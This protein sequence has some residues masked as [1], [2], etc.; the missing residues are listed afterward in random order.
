MEGVPTS[1]ARSGRCVWTVG[2]AVASVSSRTRR[3]GPG[4]SVVRRR[5]RRRWLP[6]SVQ[7]GRCVFGALR[8]DRAHTGPIVI[9]TLL[10]RSR[11]SCPRDE[12]PSSGGSLRVDDGVAVGTLRE[13]RRPAI[14]SIADQVAVPRQRSPAQRA[15]AERV[16]GVLSTRHTPQGTPTPFV[17]KRQTRPYCRRSPPWR[18]ASG[19]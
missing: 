4:A 15:Q 18:R 2:P 12:R 19:A 14:P 13:H 3:R 10:G 8:S 5:P 11:G 17:I 16:G 7:R 9:N 6:Q 1:D